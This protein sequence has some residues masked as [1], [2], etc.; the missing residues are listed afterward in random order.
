MKFVKSPFIMKYFKL[1]S[2]CLT[3]LIFTSSCV[4]S[5]K[6]NELLDKEKTCSEELA[7]YKKMSLDYE[8]LAKEL[9]MKFDLA[10]KEL[11]AIKKD[12]ALLGESFR[13]LN[14][15]YNIIKRQSAE[16]ENSFKNLKNLSAK[17]GRAHV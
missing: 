12:T 7:K 9:E 17:I 10:N 8:S 15:E 14:R 2:L 1:G 13:L 6:Y 3:L 5:K 11:M 16:L 4:P